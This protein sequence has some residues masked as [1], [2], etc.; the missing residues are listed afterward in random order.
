MKALQT[1]GAKF[2]AD[3]EFFIIRHVVIGILPYVKTTSLSGSRQIMATSAIFDMLRQ[4]K[5]PAKSQ[6][7]VV[8]KDQLLYGRSLHNWVVYLKDSYP[9]KSYST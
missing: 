6:R 7:K 4:M 8:Q 5:S 1:K 9:R 2:I 3:T